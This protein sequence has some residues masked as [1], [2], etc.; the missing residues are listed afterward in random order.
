M[1]SKLIHGRSPHVPSVARSGD[2][3]SGDAAWIETAGE[4]AGNVLSSMHQSSGA[5]LGG[6][7]L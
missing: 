7:E 6:L 4:P 2:E 5:R 3:G 1:P